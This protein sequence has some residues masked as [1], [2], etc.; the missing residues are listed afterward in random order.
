MDNAIAE[1]ND[2]TAA[3]NTPEATAGE[4]AGAQEPPPLPEPL[5]QR[6]LDKEILKKK[7]KSRIWRLRQ[8]K[9]MTC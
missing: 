9:W 3:L 7:K 2:T 5:L 6:R 4:S 1:I 8:K